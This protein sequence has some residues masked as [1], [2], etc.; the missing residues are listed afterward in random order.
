MFTSFCT[1]IG[2]HLCT[3]T[4]IIQKIT[5]WTEIPYRTINQPNCFWSII[6]MFL[7]SIFKNLLKEQ[8][9]LINLNVHMAIWKSRSS[10]VDLSHVLETRCFSQCYKDSSCSAFRLL[11]WGPKIPT[12]WHSLLWT[13]W[14]F[15]RESDRSFWAETW[16]SLLKFY[17]CCFCRFRWPTWTFFLWSIPSYLLRFRI[18]TGKEFF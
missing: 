11:V 9:F 4:E 7:F 10:K 2:T 14:A 3:K 1:Y 17:V 12:P 6:V 8:T 13:R 16:A 15:P 18:L 5:F